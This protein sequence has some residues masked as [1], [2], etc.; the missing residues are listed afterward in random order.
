[1]G[2]ECGLFGILVSKLTFYYRYILPG[3]PKLDHTPMIPRK[4]WFACPNVI[5]KSLN[6]KVHTLVMRNIILTYSTSLIQ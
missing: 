5:L 2:V 6:L 4:R 1:M 3:D